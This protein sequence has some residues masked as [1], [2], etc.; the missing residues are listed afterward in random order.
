VPTETRIDVPFLPQSGV[1]GQI[2]QALQLANEVHAQSQRLALQ[3]QAQ[4]SEIAERESTARRLDAQTELDRMNIGLR[5]ELIGN[6]TGNTPG[7]VTPA[8]APAP[9][10]SGPSPAPSVGGPS[11]VLPNGG[12][13][14]SGPGTAQSPADVLRQAAGIS[15]APAPSARPSRGGL[16]GSTMDSLLADPSLT[17]TERQAINLAGREAMLK[18]YL[19]PSTAMDG[20]VSTYNDILKQHGETA[21]TLHT[22]ILPDSHSSTGYSTVATSADGR[23]AYR[24]AAPP[25]MPKNL[26]ESSA[27]LGSASFNYQ[28]DPTPGNETALKLAGVQHDSMYQ[29]RIAEA[30]KQ[31]QA[32]AQAQGRDVEAMLRTGKNPITGEVLNLNNAPPSALVNPSTGQVIPQDMIS[33][34][35]PT[36]EEKQTAD[37][38]RQVLAI[39]KDLKDQITKNPNL[40]GPLQGRDQ[41]ALQKL[42]FSSQDAAKMIDNVSLLQS[43]ATKMHTGRFSTQIL[44]KSENLVKP[45]MGKDEFLGSLD[46]I[47]D[48]ATRYAN[49]D[50]LTTVYEYQ[51]RQQF[52]QQG[53]AAPPPGQFSPGNPFAPKQKP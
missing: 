41:Q 37:T 2:L 28:R 38:A 33:L 20:I 17:P 29:D 27:F 10:Q 42:G 15:V 13:A 50:K 11:Q 19:D 35:K 46:S 52:E 8:A 34:Y 18:S 49:E 30:R 48:V 53:G 26:E 16:I 4:P 45:G 31:A 44:Q 5:R 9:P 21:R 22:E 7:S 3:Q 24:H 51:Q 23:E 25:P 6:L 40:I 12:A 14:V 47:N 1:T 39:S 43:A 32:T 36:G